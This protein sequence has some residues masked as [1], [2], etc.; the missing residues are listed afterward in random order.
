MFRDELAS[1]RERRAT[2]GIKLEKNTL[3]MFFLS[4]FIFFQLQKKKKWKIYG[5]IEFPNKKI[6]YHNHKWIKITFSHMWRELKR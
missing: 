2:D 3:K 6:L 5:Q 1:E 4:F